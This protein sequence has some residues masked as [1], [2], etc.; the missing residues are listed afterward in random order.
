[1]FFFSKFSRRG[2]SP[3][4]ATVLLI[5]FSIAL[6]AI[7]MSWGRTFVT[8]QT[9][10]VSEQSDKEMA[11]SSNV[12][13]DWVVIS[14]DFQIFHNTSGIRFIIENIGREDITGIKVRAVTSDQQVYN[15]DDVSSLPT[16][17][18]KNYNFDIDEVVTGFSYV[19]V[20]PKISIAGQGDYVL[21][22]NY[23]L[24]IDE[25]DQRN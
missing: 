12:A 10:L 24:K 21:C 25:I 16:G 19:S 8:D 7:V 23:E 9:K 13:I 17:N 1:M 14:S 2:V 6:G 11:C 4:I 20:S 15:F 5:A 22:S 18:A 3:L